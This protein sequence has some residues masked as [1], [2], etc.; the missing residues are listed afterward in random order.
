M[1]DQTNHPPV[2][3]LDKKNKPRGRRSRLDLQQK[4]TM[5]Q[6]YAAGQS[7]SDLADQFC[8]DDTYIRKLASRH[9]V[10]KGQ[11]AMPAH[12]VSGNKPASSCGQHLIAYKRIRRG[13]DV[14]RSLEHQY[15]QYLIA[16]MSCREAAGRL[17]L[18]G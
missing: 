1:T 11:L 13:F 9:N 3:I 18:L 17:G 2:F 12:T 4:E 16:G 15:I 8:V 5:L 14:P 10:R 6:L 7:T